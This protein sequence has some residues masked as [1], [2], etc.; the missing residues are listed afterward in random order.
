MIQ[1]RDFVFVSLQSWDI[2]IGSNCKNIAMEVA[3]HNRVLYVSKPLDRFSLMKSFSDEKTQKRLAVLRGKKA[4][5]EKITDNLWNLY[6]QT[7]LESV[8]WISHSS[9]YQFFNKQNNKKLANQ[10]KNA[11][12]A[13]GF[14]NIIVLN[15][16]D[17]ISYQY[18]KEFLSPD[19]YLYY[20][21]DYLTSQPYFHKRSYLEK[22]LIEKADAIVTNSEFL[23]QYA[24]EGNEKAYFVGQG[25]DVDHFLQPSDTPLQELLHIPK[26]IIGYTGWLSSVRLDVTLLEHITQQLPDL[27]FVF[28]GP[29]DMSFT[30]SA[31]H[32][33]SNVYFLGHKPPEKIPHYIHHFDVCINPQAVNP[34]TIGNYPR[35]IDEYLMLGKPVVATKTLA[36]D[37]FRD[38][39]YLCE[40]PEDYIEQIQRALKENQPT[41]QEQRKVF[42]QSH[43]WEANVAHIYQVIEEI[44]T[45]QPALHSISK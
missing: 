38:Y 22:Q 25:C 28:V 44:H 18:L 23:R 42:A 5:L 15:D 41:L 12:Q 33:Q 37:Y 21:R 7:M 2:E 29:E 32:H 17:F 45:N 24:A 39:T 3:K 6:P 1:D 11:C 35:K 30:K 36:M 14:R 8:N 4:P 19:L 10:I 34:M 9:L 26:P 13:L 40:G 16:N 31:L 27:S 43:T 20:I